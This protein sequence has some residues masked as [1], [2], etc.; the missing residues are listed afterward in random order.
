M[1]DCRRL[2]FSF[3]V[4]PHIHQDMRAERLGLVRSGFRWRE[5]GPVAQLVRA[6]A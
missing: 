4:R 3:Q 6:H 1:A 5:F 2:R